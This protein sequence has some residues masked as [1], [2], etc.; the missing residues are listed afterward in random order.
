MCPVVGGATPRAPKIATSTMSSTTTPQA[1]AAQP[2]QSHHHARTTASSI[3]LKTRQ[4]VKLTSIKDIPMLHKSRRHHPAPSNPNAPRAHI[5]KGDFV[6]SCP[7]NSLGEG[8][9]LRVGPGVPRGFGL[10]HAG[11]LGVPLS[12]CMW[13]SRGLSPRVSTKRALFSAGTPWQ[14]HH[15]QGDRE[16]PLGSHKKRNNAPCRAALHPRRRDR[17]DNDEPLACMA[18]PSSPSRARDPCRRRRTRAWRPLEKSSYT[19]I[20]TNP[21]RKGPYTSHSP[22]IGEAFLWGRFIYFCFLSGRRRGWP[23]W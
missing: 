5:V 13:A 9:G 11:M 20:S 15:M 17:P 3:S 16:G 8:E 7:G 18:K 12:R 1:Q 23:V 14:P 21:Q 2:T 4:K 10:C 22:S 6:L 19:V